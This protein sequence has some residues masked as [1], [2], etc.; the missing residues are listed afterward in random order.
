MKRLATSL[1]SSGD[2]VTRVVKD[3]MRDVARLYLNISNDP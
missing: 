1:R 3:G 2:G